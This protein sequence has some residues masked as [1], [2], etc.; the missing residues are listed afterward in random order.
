M[1]MSY[2]ELGRWSENAL[3]GE[4][5]HPVG[6]FTV[7]RIHGFARGDRVAVISGP[8]RGVYGKLVYAGGD[9]CTDARRG[10]ES[11]RDYCA[12]FCLTAQGGPKGVDIP[13]SGDI[14]LTAA[15]LTHVD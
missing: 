5:F 13:P 2:G 6:Q 8:H 3:P 9:W 4:G 11:C 7:P 12:I 1:T 15:Q 14:W 10:Q